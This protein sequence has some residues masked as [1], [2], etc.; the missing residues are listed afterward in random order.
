MGRYYQLLFQSNLD[1]EIMFEDLSFCSQVY[2]SKVFL[3][4]IV[5]AELLN[6]ERFYDEVNSYSWETSPIFP[7]EVLLGKTSFA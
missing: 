3:C 5:A 7:G 6:K 1:S 2:I 4:K